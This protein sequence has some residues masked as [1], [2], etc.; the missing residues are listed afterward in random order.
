[1]PPSAKGG[2]FCCS[3]CE[4]RCRYCYFGRKP[5]R[6]LDARTKWLEDV[7]LLENPFP[8][9]S[10][11]IRAV[12]LGAPC[13]VCSRS[14]CVSSACSFFYSRRFCKTCAADAVDFFPSGLES[15]LRKLLQG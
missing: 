3:I 4:F 13:S 6:D 9:E 1:M 12:C 14:V 2:E 15:D 8:D 11:G 5:S 10:E 7:F